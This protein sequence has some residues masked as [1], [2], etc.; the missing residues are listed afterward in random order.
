MDTNALYYGDNL[1]I[2]KGYVKNESV[3]L[4]YLDP[5]FN[6]KQNY[7]VLFAEQDEVCA[8]AQIKAFGDTWSW[9]TDSARSYREIVVMGGTV[10]QVM[11]A[12][13]TFLGENNMLA[14]LSMMAPRLTELRRVLKPTGSIYLHC[15]PTAS[16]YLKLLMDAVFGAGN[17]RNEIVWCYKSGGASKYHF[18]KKHDIIF[19]YTKINKFAFN[20]EK[21]KSYGETG[22]GQGGKVQYYKDENGTYSYAGIKDWWT[23][24]MLSTTHSERLGYPTQK[25]EA[26]MERI[27]TASSNDG[28]VILDPF[29]GC[30]TTIAVAERLK[31][32]GH[33]RNWIGIDNTHLAI[34]L[35]KNRLSDMT[36]G[37]A[38]Y[39]VIGEPVALQGAKELAD[40]DKYQFQG[41]N[42]ECF[43]PTNQD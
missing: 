32:K 38:K 20:Y 11:Q 2:L 30:G 43:N 41:K 42:Q 24:S 15:D 33:P 10:S 21:E 40:S 25:P 29:C 28:D 14:Y 37:K 3:D 22:G 9:D 34:A 8:A 19:R 35:I 23:I 12:F 17:F 26:L 39:T 4:I 13:H 6:S 31:M 5:P 27:I 36:I 16:H 18:A 7:N 1:D